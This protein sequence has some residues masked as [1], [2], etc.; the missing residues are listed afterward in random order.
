MLKVYQLAV[1]NTWGNS[2]NQHMQHMAQWQ[3]LH[4]Y[5]CCIKGKHRLLFYYYYSCCH[6]NI[7]QLILTLSSNFTQKAVKQLLGGQA[8]RVDE[9]YWFIMKVTAATLVTTSNFTQNP[10]HFACLARYKKVW[11]FLIL[12]DS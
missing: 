3:W 4:P 6:T 5:T 8:S 2:S 12:W 1:A 10:V 7:F 11:H 9:V